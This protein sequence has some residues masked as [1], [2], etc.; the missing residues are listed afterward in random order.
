MESPQQRRRE[1]VGAETDAKSLYTI[2]LD[3]ILWRIRSHGKVFQQDNGVI[4][5]A[6]EKD[7]FDSCAKERLEGRSPKTGR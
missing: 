7:C 6:S 1:K 2:V 3:T 4:I 5:F